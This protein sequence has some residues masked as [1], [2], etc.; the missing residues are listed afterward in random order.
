MET[1]PQTTNTTQSHKAHRI[2]KAQKT[3]KDLITTQADKMQKDVDK[4]IPGIQ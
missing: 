2:H 1:P 4:E 3:H